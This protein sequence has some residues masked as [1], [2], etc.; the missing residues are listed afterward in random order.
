MKFLFL[1]VVGLTFGVG[2]SYFYAMP[3][4]PNQAPSLVKVND[5]LTRPGE[6]QGKYVMLSDGI[7]IAPVFVGG[8]CVF[9]IQSRESDETIKA[10]SHRLWETHTPVSSGVFQFEI[11]Y[12]DP[13]SRFLLLREVKFSN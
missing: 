5:L 12:S 8:R 10:I 1:L 9:L 6:Y 3:T 7:A 11:V 13:S 4:A 2:Y